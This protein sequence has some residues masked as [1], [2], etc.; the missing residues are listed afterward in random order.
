MNELFVAVPG[1]SVT[2]VAMLL[3]LILYLMIGWALIKMVFGQRAIDEAK[4]HL[5]AEAVKGLLR[6]T[7]T[8]TGGLAVGGAFLFLYLSAAQ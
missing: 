1:W 5:L 7:L 8:R 4:G 6:M 3:M 2:P